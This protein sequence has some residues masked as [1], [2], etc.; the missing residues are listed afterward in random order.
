MVEKRTQPAASREGTHLILYDGVCGLCSRLV[1]FVLSH[2][3]LRVF[4][5]ASLQSTIGHEF[6]E[7]AGGDPRD[8]NS[9]YV[10]ADYRAG[11]S[12][13]FT[14]SDAALFVLDRLG[15]PWKAARLIRVIPTRLRDL[16]YDALARVRYRIFG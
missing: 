7:R 10:V 16:A 13:T 12:R 5:F 2:D 14:K 6:V 11:D 1:Q 3:A 4:N 9:F 8:L 15:W